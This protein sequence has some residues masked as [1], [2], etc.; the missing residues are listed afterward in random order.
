MNVL[1]TTSSKPRAFVMAAI[2]AM[3]VI[4]SVGFVGDSTHT[5]RVLG[6]IAF[7]SSPSTVKSTNENVMP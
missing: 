3:S 6:V 4:F 5:M 2:F 7:S 1:S